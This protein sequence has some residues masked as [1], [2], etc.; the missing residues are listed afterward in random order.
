MAEVVTI[1]LTLAFAFEKSVKG[2]D[3]ASL[4][5]DLPR[6]MPLDG[7]D[8]ENDVHAIVGILGEQ[9]WVDVKE[10]RGSTRP[11]TFQVDRHIQRV[12]GWGVAMKAT[13]RLRLIYDGCRRPILCKPLPTIGSKDRGPRAFHDYRCL[14]VWNLRREA[15]A[16][17]DAEQVHRNAD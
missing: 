8:E 3:K 17:R 9:R 6:G 10:Y 14:A 15:E 7:A 5:F 2:G 12:P 16:I 13:L 4:P 1:V 11:A